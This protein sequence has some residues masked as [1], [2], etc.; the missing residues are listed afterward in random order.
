[1]I[2]ETWYRRSPDLPLRTSA[3]GVVV[4][5]ESDRLLVALVREA[6]HMER[7]LPKGGVEPGESLEDAARREI[8]EEAGLT[9]L[10]CLSPLGVRERLNYVRSTWITI[11]YFLFLT[12]QVSGDPSDTEHDYHLEWWPLDA[13]PP[14]LWPEQRRLIKDNR[15]RIRELAAP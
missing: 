3:G 15:E 4:R 11:H 5:R 14:M 7:I 13:L 1:M 2:D 6:P 10:E 12:D 8:A 9:D